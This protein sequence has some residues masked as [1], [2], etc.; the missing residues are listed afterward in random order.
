MD[1]PHTSTIRFRPIVCDSKPKLVGQ[2]VC[3]RCIRC[4]SANSYRCSSFFLGYDAF[5]KLGGLAG[6]YGLLQVMEAAVK[7]KIGLLP[8]PSKQPYNGYGTANTAIEYHNASALAL[9]EA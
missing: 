3:E 1:L 4:E 9:Q 8:K 6:F 7:Q 2:G 5:L